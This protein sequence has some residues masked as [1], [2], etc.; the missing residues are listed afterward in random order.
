MQVVP[1][2]LLLLAQC[3]G[4]ENIGMWGWIVARQGHFGESEFASARTVII[5]SRRATLVEATKSPICRFIVEHVVCTNTG[6]QFGLVYI[7]SV[8]SN[9]T[10]FNDLNSTLNDSGAGMSP[11]PFQ[12][13]GDEYCWIINLAA[14]GMGFNNVSGVTPQLQYRG[15]G[16]ISLP[17]F[18]SSL[19]ILTRTVVIC[20]N[21]QTLSC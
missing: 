16:P 3:E 11:Q 14:L 19:K 1:R 9:V 2:Y 10:C 7:V 6:M 12:V 8:S 18:N 21:A 13:N 15:M 4:A 5:H 20:T 17:S